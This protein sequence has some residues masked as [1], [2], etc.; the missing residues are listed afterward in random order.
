MYPLVSTENFGRIKWNYKWE[1]RKL[2][3]QIFCREV[4]FYPLQDI[5]QLIW[6]EAIKYILGSAT[7]VL[8]RNDLIAV[9]ISIDDVL[10]R[11]SA[12]YIS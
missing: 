6:Q 12:A 3:P 7:T 2:A 8:R 11:Y 4:S 5:T 9:I 10:G 1:S